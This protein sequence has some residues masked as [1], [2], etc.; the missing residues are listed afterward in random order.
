M[1]VNAEVL[2]RQWEGI[3]SRMGVAERREHQAAYKRC[4]AR[5]AKSVQN[6]IHQV[7][8]TLQEF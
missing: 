4:L 8:Q 1:K 5:Q 2:A 3:V 6:Q 7:N